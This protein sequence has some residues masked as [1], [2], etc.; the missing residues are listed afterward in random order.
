MDSCFRATYVAQFGSAYIKPSLDLDV[1][2]RRCRASAQRAPVRSVLLSPRPTRWLFAASPMVEFG[3]TY[4]LAN[5]P[6]LRSFIS[7]G[8]TV[9]SNNT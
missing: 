5:G 6:A 2:I 1:I 7:G 9:L 3:Q 8:A 4:F